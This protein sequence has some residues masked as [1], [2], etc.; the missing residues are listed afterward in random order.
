MS[1]LKAL[2]MENSIM[3]TY[4]LRLD[5]LPQREAFVIMRLMAAF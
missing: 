4:E 2:R 1:I 3:L 5:F